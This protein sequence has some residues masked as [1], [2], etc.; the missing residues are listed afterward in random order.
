MS[1]DLYSTH[2]YLGPV[3]SNRGWA[4]VLDALDGAGDGTIQFFLDHGYTDRPD[5][6]ATRLQ[7]VMPDLRADVATTVS[8]L[9]LL[10]A[11]AHESFALLS[12][13]VGQEH[14]P[15]KSQMSE[16]LGPDG[17]FPYLDKPLR[18]E[19]DQ[20]PY[21]LDDKEPKPLIW[22]DLDGVLFARQDPFDPATVGAPLEKGID[23]VRRLKDEGFGLIVHTARNKPD[24]DPVRAALDS[25]PEYRGLPA[26][27]VKPL[28]A[29]GGIDDRVANIKEPIETLVR[30]MKEFVALR[31]VFSG[32]RVLLG[33]WGTRSYQNDHAQDVLDIF[34]NRQDGRL[35]PVGFEV[36][37]P[38]SSLPNFLAY[39]DAIPTSDDFGKEK[40]LGP[41]I[42]MARLGTALPPKYL[43][44]ALQIIDG[45]LAD[46][47]YL[48]KW[49]DPAQRRASLER[50]RKLLTR[51]LERHAKTG[52]AKLSERRTKPNRTV[53]SPYFDK[54]VLASERFT[55][56]RE[57]DR[58]QTHGETQLSLL[59]SGPLRTR[60]IK[61]MSRQAVEQLHAGRKPSE[62][63]FSHDHQAQAEVAELLKPVYDRARQETRL[64]L[65]RQ[66]QGRS[67]NLSELLA[68]TG[69]VHYVKPEHYHP[70]DWP[71]HE[72]HGISAK[73]YVV[74]VKKP[75]VGEGHWVT[76]SGTHVYIGA[77]GTI[78]KG[79]GHMIGKK[80]SEIQ[81]GPAQSGLTARGTPATEHLRKQDIPAMAAALIS[82][83]EH[84]RQIATEYLDKLSSDDLRKLAEGIAVNPISV[85]SIYGLENAVNFKGYADGMAYGQT[86]IFSTENRPANEAIISRMSEGDQ[87]KFLSA[88]EGKAA[89]APLEDRPI[90]RETYGI[91]AHYGTG[92]ASVQA[93]KDYARL[94]ASSSWANAE[95]LAGLTSLGAAPGEAY[96]LPGDHPDQWKAM[97]D[98]WY[99]SSTN[100]LC[101]AM[102]YAAQG[103]GPNQGKSLLI[104]NGRH[105]ASIQTHDGNP[106]MKE[107]VS[108]IYNMSQTE[109]SIM[110]VNEVRLF[111][112]VQSGVETFQPLESWTTRPDIASNFDNHGIME[113]T[114]PREAIW[115]TTNIMKGHDC[116]KGGGH[117]REHIV[118]GGAIDR[119]KLKYYPHGAGRPTDA[120]VLDVQS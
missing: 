36:P 105:E 2:G 74:L 93:A 42:L 52:A 88:V 14:G 1:L 41:V 8:S 53:Q 72:H 50:E 43:A 40:Y 118:L 69:H 37:V 15:S 18:A 17:C 97:M 76:I 49:K 12:D 107:R 30:R 67:T 85:R 75:P 120:D 104:L 113:T 64:E 119:S 84:V 92:Q 13:G 32:S 39:L 60:I 51:L 23:L 96:K 106:V 78:E 80:P 66:L 98:Q 29:I 59:L 48:P 86:G 56:F 79:P 5:K 117:E 27:N 91:V 94:L 95:E 73:G 19:G 99:D 101:A 47:A 100:P 89:T 65:D 103:V 70:E 54:P 55:N 68:G 111:R 26:T 110:G 109:L 116:W 3:A 7:A 34:R 77:D 46:P 6:L 44:K 31:E 38:E 21:A 28:E 33:A 82:G 61:A 115:T 9:V 58:L 81:R 114:V 25:V 112:G 87:T 24:E 83:D 62:L 20:N 63:Q 22:L 90:L 11:R 35:A 71:E 57:I 108:E 102:K 45:F 16:H 10:L 4:D